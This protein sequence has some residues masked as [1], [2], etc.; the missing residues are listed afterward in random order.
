[1]L[2]THR[3]CS[4]D[5]APSPPPHQTLLAAALQDASTRRLFNA[6]T[7]V[8]LAV[9]AGFQAAHYLQA[10]KVRTRAEAFF[11]WVGWFAGEHISVVVPKKLWRMGDEYGRCGSVSCQRAAVC[12]DMQVG[13]VAL[14]RDVAS[15]AA[16]HPTNAPPHLAPVS[17][18]L[19]VQ[20]C[21]CPLRLP[22]HTVHPLH[23]PAH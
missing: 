6:E 4:A 21:V 11:R 22:R 9:A 3:F 17:F 5:H 20:A 18:A 16:R 15:C 7:R 23:R 10:Q 14:V 19:P 8:S 12:C 13:H 2:N 1:V